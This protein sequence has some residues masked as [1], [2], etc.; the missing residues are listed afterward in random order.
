[1]AKARLERLVS[2]DERSRAGKL[3]GDLLK[4]LLEELLSVTRR[5]RR[6]EGLRFLLEGIPGAAKDIYPRE[7][8]LKHPRKIP[9]AKPLHL[10]ARRRPR[11]DPAR[12]RARRV[13]DL[14]QRRLTS[15]S[16]SLPRLRP[17]IRI[18]KARIVLPHGEHQP[19]VLLGNPLHLV[20]LAG[21]NADFVYLGFLQRLAN[22]RHSSP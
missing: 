21:V 5:H 17:V 14:G 2:V 8:R 16:L 9:T 7:E 4:S 18:D 10:L 22:R 6:V 12:E 11:F 3:A 15:L 20:L 13:S 19:D 1:M